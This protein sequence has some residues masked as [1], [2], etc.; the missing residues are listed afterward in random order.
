MSN[1]NTSN[2]ESSKKPAHVAEP[3]MAEETLVPEYISKNAKFFVLVALVGSLVWVYKASTEYTRQAREDS[4]ILTL[5]AANTVT[6]AQEII[7]TWPETTAAPLARIRLAKLHYTNGNYDRAEAVYKEFN[8]LHP[9][10]PLQP[11]A[12]LGIAYCLESKGELQGAIDQYDAFLKKHSDVSYLTP[13]AQ[14]GKARCLTATG[15]LDD[16]RVMYEDF[17]AAQDERSVW[18]A[19]A[20]EYLKDLEVKIKR[21]EGTL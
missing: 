3:R 7:D 16:A 12:D 15:K 6:A 10:H 8:S 20:Q 1:T 19:M 5:S 14:M 9:D 4:A 2:T 18:G 11:A 21:A 13:V 17:I